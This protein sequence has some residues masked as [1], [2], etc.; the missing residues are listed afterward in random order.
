MTDLRLQKLCH[1]LVERADTTLLPS[2]GFAKLADDYLVERLKEDEMRY[3]EVA[4]GLYE[5]LR[6]LLRSEVAPLYEQ[7]RRVCDAILERKHKRKLIY[8]VGGTIIVFELLEVIL[9]RGKSLIP[10]VLIPNL[11]ASSFVGFMVYLATQY[12]DDLFLTRARRQFLRS[13]QC[14]DQRVVTDAE[15]DNRRRLAEAD[16]LKAETM[17]IISQYAGANEFWADY[18]KVRTLDPT[19]PNELRQLNLPPFEK[20][21]KHHASG[22]CS[23][24][25]RQNRFNQL[26]LEAHAL[27]VAKDRERYALSTLKPPEARS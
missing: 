23:T 8:Y 25:S 15:Y 13:C 10:A 3:A 9:T 26:F 4:P 24:F 22:E 11:L 16:V 14:L 19:T 5:E 7:Y 27:Y 2:T 12:I 17:E 20:F 18:V 6:Q 1:E 21:L